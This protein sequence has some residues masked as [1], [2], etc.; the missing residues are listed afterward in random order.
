MS[1]LILF[2]TWINDDLQV[3]FPLP[4]VACNLMIEYSD[5]YENF[6]VSSVIL[7]IY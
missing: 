3:D 2:M 4:I 5:F 7:I 1:D 6:Q